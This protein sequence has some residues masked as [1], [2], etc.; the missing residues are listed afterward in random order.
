MLRVWRKNMRNV[1]GVWWSSYQSKV[2]M[3]KA[4]RGSGQNENQR[5]ILGSREGVQWDIRVKRKV[6]SAAQAMSYC[7]CKG[8]WER[9]RKALNRYQGSSWKSLKTKVWRLEIIHG[10][11]KRDCRSIRMQDLRRAQEVQRVTSNGDRVWSSS[12]NWCQ[13]AWV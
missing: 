1:K 3:G 10:Q 9:M 6:D 13:R 5:G 4:K 8:T 2:L 7:T 11:K 12:V